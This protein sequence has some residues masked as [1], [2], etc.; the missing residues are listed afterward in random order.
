MSRR[1]GFEYAGALYHVINLGNYRSWIFESDGA[2]QSFETTLFEACEYAGWKLHAIVAMGNH[3]HL[4]LESSEPNLSEGMWWLQ[5]VFASR[6]NRFRKENGRLFQGRFKSVLVEDF[7]RLSWLCHY[8]HLNPVRTAIWKVTELKDYRSGSHWYLRNRRKRPQSLD[9][10][11]CLGGAGGLKDSRAGW[12]KYDAYL[13]WLGEEHNMGVDAGVSRLA[14][15]A[16]Q[17]ELPGSETLLKL[18]NTQFK[19]L[20]LS[21]K[22][23]C[24]REESKIVQ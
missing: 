17:G 18:L 16:Q 2:K 13:E 22:V 1:L 11:T 8:I 14:A 19:E 4:A 24:S 23:P 15:R 7:D 21:F 5:S 20:S 6:F 10:E 12:K 3:F 9:L